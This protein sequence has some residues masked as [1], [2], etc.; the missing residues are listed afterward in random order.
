MLSQCQAADLELTWE[1]RKASRALTCS[2]HR[3]RGDED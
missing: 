2:G 1:G 3:S